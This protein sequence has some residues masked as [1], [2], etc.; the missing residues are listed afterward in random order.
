MIRTA[1]CESGPAA[2]P[3]RARASQIA[4]M[5]LTN[6]TAAKAPALSA[7]SAIA[8][9]SAAASPSGFSA[10]IGTP[11]A[12]ADG[13]SLREEARDAALTSRAPAPAGPT[14]N[15]W[16][17]RLLMGEVSSQDAEHAVVL[18]VVQP[19][20]AGLMDGSVS[21]LAPIFAVAFATRSP[22]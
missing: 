18:R 2:G 10:T 11:R 1:R 22:H 20:L 3:S 7:R 5:R 21:T 8:S 14:F 17:T 4:R 16:L 12:M 9:T 6:A 19:A 13:T 15:L